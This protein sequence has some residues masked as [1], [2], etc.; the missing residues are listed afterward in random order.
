V[1]PPGFR[2]SFSLLRLPQTDDDAPTHERAP[3]PSLMHPVHCAVAGPTCSQ[4]LGGNLW[5]LWSEAAQVGVILGPRN[6]A[7]GGFAGRSVRPRAAA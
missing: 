4:P 6:R 5:A 2:L 3:P 1:G 7:R